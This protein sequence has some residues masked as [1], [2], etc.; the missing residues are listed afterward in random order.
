MSGLLSDLDGKASS[1]LSDL[2]SKVS[3]LLF[4]LDGN[5][6]LREYFTNIL[7]LG[8][9]LLRSPDPA[10]CSYACAIYRHAFVAFDL[11]CQQGILDY[12]DNL[13]LSQIRK[14]FSMLSTLAF[15]SRREGA[16]IQ[17]DVHI[18]IRKQLSS[19]CPKYKRIGIIGAVMIVRS[20]ARN[21]SDDSDETMSTASQY[22]ST[23][24][25]DLY[26]Q[27]VHLL[28]MVRASVNRVP[29]AAALF[30][31]ELTRV[32]E[33]GDVDRKIKNWISETVVSDFQDDFLVDR[34]AP[35]PVDTLPIEH[36]YGLDEAEEG[37]IALNMLPLL[38]AANSKKAHA[39]ERS[40][41]K[42]PVFI[43]CTPAN[44][45]PPITNFRLFSA[46]TTITRYPW[47]VFD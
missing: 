22:H 16:M 25:N 20:M 13:T 43:G 46:S 35:L 31:D 15:S 34:E 39:N 10:V 7:S 41:Y 45:Q 4:D 42:R 8:E 6:V 9:V 18:V 44:A 32:I 36:V 17:D 27:I 2:D 14:V 33:Q 28:E 11:Y 23:I 24:S 19:D 1:L 37:S 26:K 5:K 38:L 12:L 40:P 47:K 29:E 21:R 3:I 30:Y